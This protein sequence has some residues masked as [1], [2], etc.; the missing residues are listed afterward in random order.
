M[1]GETPSEASTAVSSYKCR[2]VI[3]G[4][5]LQVADRTAVHEL[6][7]EV[8]GPPAAMATARTVLGLAAST[9]AIASLAD[10][11]QAFVQCRIDGPGRPR[12]WVRLPK[13]W[14]PAEWAGMYD[15][16]VPLERALYGHPESGPLW[17]KH[18]AGMLIALKYVRVPSC[19]GTWFRN[20]DRTLLVVYVDDI[21][22]VC[23]KQ[24]Y[25]SCWAEIS[26]QVKF[27]E[28]PE[29]VSRYLGV[30]HV[31]RREP[32]GSVVLTHLVLEMRLFIA[33]AVELYLLDIG[34][35]KLSIV[36]TPYLA[37]TCPETPEEFEKGVLG[38]RASSHLMK[39]LYAARMACPWLITQ[40]VRLAKFVSCWLVYHDKA[41]HR[42][43]CFC[44]ANP[45]VVLNGSMC[46]SDSDILELHL[47]A[48][49]DQAGDKNTTKSTSGMWLELFAPK[50]EVLLEERT[51][52]VEWC[53][54]KQSSTA[55][56]TAEAETIS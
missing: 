11:E 38:H 24:F 2:A 31:F 5:N 8:A 53:S 27:K 44:F 54:K 42:L 41:L 50:T 47:H 3:G 51:W 36:D 23:F 14:W 22:M 35:V 7:Q 39:L 4:N 10:A 19:P 1:A 25:D 6:F 45:D 17:D 52:P 9:G 55:S 40:I 28:L 15:P 26:L 34:K 20:C 49:A 16:V 21:M 48:D 29:P 13:A 32:V 12:S 37:S 46:S 33:Q 56:S 18:F 43:F 30:N